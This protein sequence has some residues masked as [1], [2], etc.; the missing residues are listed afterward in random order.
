MPPHVLL[1]NAHHQISSLPPHVPLLT[2]QA[3]SHVLRLLVLHLSP[4]ISK[5]PRLPQ[6]PSGEGSGATTSPRT[7]RARTRAL[8]PPSSPRPRQPI[9]SRELRTRLPAGLERGR[10]AWAGAGLM[11]D[12][13]CSD[14]G[15][16]WEEIEGV[17]G[18]GWGGVRLNMGLNV[19]H[20]SCAQPGRGMAVMGWAN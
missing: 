9:G 15:T 17:D 18:T 2:I 8:H 12:C 11:G 19:Q 3:P 6:T 13:G 20:F 7:P 4:E 14:G 16:L 1:N 5:S 10:G